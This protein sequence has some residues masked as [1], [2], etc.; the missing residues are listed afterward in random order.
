MDTNDE[1][2]DEEIIEE[3]RYC[4][5]CSKRIFSFMAD[6]MLY[7][8]TYFPR[9]YRGFQCEGVI[10]LCKKCFR[11]MQ[12]D[13]IRKPPIQRADK[14]WGKKIFAPMREGMCDNCEKEDV[15]YMV[16]FPTGKKNL[17]GLDKHEKRFFC[18][19]CMANL[20]EYLSSK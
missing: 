17:L 8:D 1:I 2:Y 4:A 20:T 12:A 6:Y 10:W 15:L 16:E 19:T 14:K 18:K 5:K 13:W 11:R 3:S 9:P 7:M